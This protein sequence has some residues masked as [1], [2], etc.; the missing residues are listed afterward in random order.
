M[1]KQVLI[2]VPETEKGEG[3][4]SSF[5]LVKK[6]DGSLRTIINL[7]PLNKFIIKEKFRMETINFTINLLF[8]NCYMVSVDLKDAYYHVPIHPKVQR[9]LRVAV[10]LGAKICHFQYQALP[11]GITIAPRI[12]TKIVAEVSAHLRESEGIVIPYRDDFLLVE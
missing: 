1:D 9:Y 10:R 5:F 2:P 3:F 6:P 12:F 4:Y 11:F 7:K 8:K